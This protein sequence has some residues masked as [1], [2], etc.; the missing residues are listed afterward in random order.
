MI[1]STFISVNQHLNIHEDYKI[2]KKKLNNVIDIN[3]FF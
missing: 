3:C 2:T 1:S